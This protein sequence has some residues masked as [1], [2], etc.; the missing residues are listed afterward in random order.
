MK[1][2]LFFLSGIAFL[3]N[4][5]SND[6][7]TNSVNPSS[8]VLPVKIIQTYEDG[9]SFSVDITYNGNKVLKLIYSDGTFVD[10][11]YSD[12]IISKVEYYRNEVLYQEEFFQYDNNDRLVNHKRFEYENVAQDYDYAKDVTYSYNLDGTVSSIMMSGEVLDP[13]FTDTAV[14]TLNDYGEVILA[15]HN[16]G[17]IESFTYDNKNSPFKNILGFDKLRFSGNNPTAYLH[18]FISEV[19]PHNTTT[20]IYT[21]NSNDYPLTDQENDGYGISTTQYFYNN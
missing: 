5:C 2:I 9:S 21:Y 6:D 16:Q 3:L 15:N 13:N 4:S 12:N 14:F 19:N 8:D 7:S 11:I 1:K 17:Y 18:N 10:Y 20:H